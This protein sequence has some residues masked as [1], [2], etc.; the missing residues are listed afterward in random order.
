MYSPLVHPSSFYSYLFIP[1]H[2]PSPLCNW[3]IHI[4]SFFFSTH[5]T[6]LN[7]YKQT[8]RVTKSISLSPPPHP[9]QLTYLTRN[10]RLS[11][12]RLHTTTLYIKIYQLLVQIECSKVERLLFYCR[13]KTKV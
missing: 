5:T 10:T 3:N 13:I 8:N 2:L 6:L 1:L 11:Q 9:P 12:W 7:R 4:H